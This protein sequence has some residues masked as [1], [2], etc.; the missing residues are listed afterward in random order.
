MAGVIEMT[1]RRPSLSPLL[2]RMRGRSPGLADGLLGGVF[3][4]GLGLGALAVLVMVL[5]ISSPYPDSGPGGALHIAAALWVLAHGA[6]LVRTD[7]LS[8]VS[9][10]V[11]VT[12]LLLLALPVWLV[13]RAARD[14]TEGREEGAPLLPARTAWAGVV[15]GYL[16]VGAPAVLYAAGGE[17]RPSWVGAG[18]CV[19]LVAVVAAG[20]GV[21]SA[22]GCPGRPVE[23]VLRR[24]L[25]V[26]VRRLLLCPGGRLGVAA[27]AA[28]A[29]ATV[30]VGGGALL[31]AV[32]LVWHGEV[33]RGSFLQLTEAW[34]G[35]FAVLL[36]C[37]VLVPNAAVWAVAY[38]VGPGFALGAGHVVGPLAADPA[39]LLP[40]FPLL[41]AVPEAGVGGPV[42]WVVGV[43]PVMG[44]VVVGWFVGRAAEVVGGE[45]VGA[46]SWRR[47]AGA[48]GAAAGVCA[49]LLAGFAGLAGG[50]LGGGAL[51]RFGPVWWQVGGAVAVWVG[52]VAVPVAV[53]VRGWRCRGKSAD[54][55][56]AA[57]SGGSEERRRFR[58][59]RWRA[60]G[61]GAEGREGAERPVVP[62]P[63]EAASAGGYAPVLRAYDDDTPYGVVDRDDA[64][65]SPYDLLPSSDGPT[66]PASGARWDDDAT[67]RARWDALT[68]ASTAAESAEPADTPNTL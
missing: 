35:R 60:R 12:P 33:A 46:R 1:A 8:G 55:G 30:L 42:N 13:H 34:S 22:Y 29:G 56:E 36:L 43:V 5:W 45:G 20:S 52:V 65:L 54:G 14:A 61:K 39:P 25:P 58:G 59:V 24:V 37:A 6:E 47:T 40:P 68:Q 7:T 17:L 28:A 11:G 3:A 23:R 44:G 32:S 64:T 41:A 38:A 19:P 16:A 27:R 21:W 57:G 31:V 15:L 67:R 26:G 63:A 51:A 66:E 49:G 10:P 2:T 53:G 9:A 50:P 18:V 62:E 4:A 48:A